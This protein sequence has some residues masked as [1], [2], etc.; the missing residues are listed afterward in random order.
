MNYNTTK[1]KTNQ[2]RIANY[3]FD[4]FKT[5]IYMFTILSLIFVFFVRE[6]RVD[7]ASMNDTLQD[8]DIV[9]LTTFMYEPHT[10]DIVAIDTDYLK[11]QRIIKRVIATEGQ[12]LQIDYNNKRVIVDGV[13]L[14]EDY[15]S[16]ATVRPTDEYDVPYVIP[17]GMVFVMGDNRFRS[18]DSRDQEVGLINVENI[19]GKAQFIF[20]PLDRI[21][22]LY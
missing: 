1:L 14:D 16:S 3:I 15:L 9:A 18:K 10:G 12:T 20:Y 17:E 6:V 19:I 5:L 11:E 21:T 13:V 7:G 2:N 22:Y 8:K 4:L